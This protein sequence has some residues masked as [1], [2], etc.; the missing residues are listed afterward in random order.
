MTTGS[1]GSCLRAEHDRYYGV[2]HTVDNWL[3]EF[4]LALGPEAEARRARALPLIA[5]DGTRVPDHI[6][7]GPDLHACDCQT[8]L[9]REE[10]S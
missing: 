6:I 3:T 4:S 1:G 2:I 7:S 9:L 5:Q 8:T 10:E